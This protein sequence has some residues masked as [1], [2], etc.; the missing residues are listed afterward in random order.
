MQRVKSTRVKR[1]RP[2]RVP[3]AVIEMPEHLLDHAVGGRHPDDI[4]AV[5]PDL[6]LVFGSGRLRVRAGG[7]NG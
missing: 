1:G 4:L 3:Q 5:L 7:K 6:G 2:V